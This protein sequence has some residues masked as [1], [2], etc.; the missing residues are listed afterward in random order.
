M[1]LV[2]DTNILVAALI[3]KGTPPDLLFEA[4]GAGRFELVSCSVQLDELKVVTRRDRIRTLITPA[5]AGRMIN[6]LREL[7][8]FLDQWPRVD[9]S[10]DPK[11]NYLLGLCEASG[12]EYLVTGDRRDLLALGSHASARIVT[13]REALERLKV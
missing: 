7:T 11:D 4:W 13:A 10:P 8:V 3:T 5:E 9:L 12:A 2:L 1:R 6:D